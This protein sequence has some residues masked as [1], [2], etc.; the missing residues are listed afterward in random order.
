MDVGVL[1]DLLKPLGVAIPLVAILFYL[2]R[3]ATEERKSITSDFLLTLRETI[4]SGAETSQTVASQL[5]RIAD[6]TAER[7]RSATA[8]HERITQ[9]LQNIAARLEA[10]VS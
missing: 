6:E 7:T 10:R 2:L 8:E 5:A 4:K 9:T 1:V 3:Q